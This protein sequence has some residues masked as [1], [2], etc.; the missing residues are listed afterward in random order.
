[1]ATRNQTALKGGKTMQNKKENPMD[2]NG[3]SEGKYRMTKKT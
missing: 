2:M 3:E 1:M